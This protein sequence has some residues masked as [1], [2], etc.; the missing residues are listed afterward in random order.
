VDYE[1]RNLQRCKLGR[2]DEIPLRRGFLPLFQ[3]VISEVPAL[4]P[5]VLTTTGSGAAVCAGAKLV[6]EARI[7]QH[8]GIPASLVN[9]GF[10]VLVKLLTEQAVEDGERLAWI[11]Y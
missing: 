9:H 1:V 3:L 7:R 5:R 11:D 2:Q 6:V 10:S 4:S 8:A